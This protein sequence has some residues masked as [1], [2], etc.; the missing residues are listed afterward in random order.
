MGWGTKSVTISQEVKGRMG[1]RKDLGGARQQEPWG[2]RGGRE[3]S[4][5]PRRAEG[6]QSGQ[7]RINFVP[8]PASAKESHWRGERGAE[9]KNAQLR[10][11]RKNM[12]RGTGDIGTRKA[13]VGR[14]ERA[15]PSQTNGRAALDSQWE[16]QACKW[17]PNP[18]PRTSS[19]VAETGGK[20]WSRAREVERG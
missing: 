20:M 4:G 6:N 14:A 2:M 17:D 16:G 13:G 12:L 15:G 8:E 3:S 5:E 1:K 10:N 19:K 18:I 9:A 11:P 7:E